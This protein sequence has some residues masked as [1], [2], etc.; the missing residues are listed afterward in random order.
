MAFSATTVWETNAAATGGDTSNGGGFDPGNASMATDLAATLATSAA[1]VVTSAS[2]NFITRDNGH[3]LFIK[4]GTNWIPGEYPVA[5]TSGN[6]ATLNA[7]VGAV[8]LFTNGAFSGLNT[9]AG[10]ATVASPTGGTWSIDYSQSTAAA[11]TFTD[12]VINGATNTSFTSAANPIGKNFVGNVISVTSG[13][14]FTVQRIQFA[15]VT[16]TTGTADKSLGTLSST[17]GNGG[18][19]GALATPSKANTLAVTNNTVFLKAGTYSGAVTTSVATFWVGYNTTRTLSNRDSTRVLWQASA[20]S[21]T[22]FTAGGTAQVIANVDFDANGKTGCTGYMGAQTGTEAI[23]CKATGLATGFSSSWHGVHHVDCY[24]SGCGTSYLIGGGTSHD[25]KAIGCT[26]SGSTSVAFSFGGTGASAYDCLA[27]NTT[28]VAFSID[29]GSAA[30]FLHNCSAYNS[31]SHNYNIS[32][33]GATLRNCVGYTTTNST[34]YN[35]NVSFTGSVTVFDHCAGGN[36]VTGTTNGFDS[37]VLNLGFITLTANP[38]TNT[39]GGDYSLN[40]TAG[41]GALLRG[42]GSPATFTGLATTAS[43]PDIGASQLAAS[44]SG[45]PVAGNLRGGYVNG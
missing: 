11:V 40:N 13:T 1:P 15:S 39:A 5:S 25:C 29:S 19:G 44:T 32:T 37:M 22:I 8:R 20:N 21:Q 30:C 38:F 4:T 9:V 27:I 33:S 28:G 2:Y 43:A 35:Y 45:G 23:N 3:Y 14:G 10:C 12:L 42:V 18:L 26:A 17:G 6:A 16:G 41:G 31:T 24:A 34:T 7:A 36:A